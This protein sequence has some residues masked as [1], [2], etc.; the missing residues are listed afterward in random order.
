MSA[1][2]ATGFAA[3]R[4]D[5]RLFAD[6]SFGLPAGSAMLLR[7]PNG[8]GKSTLLKGLIG[9]AALDAGAIAFAG[10]AFDARSRRLAR[11]VLYQGHATG[12]KGELTVLDGLRFAAELDGSPA[13]TGTLRDALRGLGLARLATV[14]AR[15]LSQ[16][17]RQRLT[18]CRFALGNPRPLWLLDEPSSA[19]DADGR[20]LLDE[21]LSAHLDRGGGAIIAT[22]L[23]LDSVRP[24]PAILDLGQHLPAAAAAPEAA[25]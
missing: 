12:L 6:L 13:D 25:P 7:G 2:Q 19:L 22:H 4:G 10:E 8:S 18:L 24:P 23:A 16:G 3:T 9:L 17:Q 11:H 5:R 1:L 20:R 21:L 15:R 14:E